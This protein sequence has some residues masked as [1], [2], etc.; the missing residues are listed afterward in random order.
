MPV[1]VAGV[2]DEERGELAIRERDP[3]GLGAVLD[4]VP[5][6]SV[7]E[8][9]VVVDIVAADGR[10]SASSRLVRVAASWPTATAVARRQR[11]LTEVMW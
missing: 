10:S 4:G 6:R 5:V 2:V 9:V 11:T 1:H 3:A 7:V 8:Q